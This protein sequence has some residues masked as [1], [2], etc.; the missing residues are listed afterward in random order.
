MKRLSALLL[1]G[2]ALGGAAAASHSATS[3]SAQSFR[4]TVYFL[5]DGQSAPLGV[6][7]TVVRRGFTPLA[8][9]AV[10]Q[11]LAWPSARER[12]E[13]L[14]SAIP[15]DAKIRSD[16]QHIGPAMRFPSR[17]QQSATEGPWEPWRLRSQTLS[18]RK[19]ML[20]RWPTC[21]QSW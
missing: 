3:A 14:T 8:R 1:V 4:I 21:A 19:E 2:L 15:A 18:W 11:L 17:F 13:G 12:S 5:T 9:L 6:R 20:R 7:R 10:Q 16:F